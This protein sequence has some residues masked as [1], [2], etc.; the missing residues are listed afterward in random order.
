[1]CG[2]LMTRTHSPNEAFCLACGRSDFVWYPFQLEQAIHD[3]L[4]RMG[5][6]RPRIDG[7]KKLDGG[8]EWFLSEEETTIVDIVKNCIRWASDSFDPP[9]PPSRYLG[10][11]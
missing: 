6:H 9:F 3:V 4:K 1:M 7:E 5:L 8:T 11:S 10:L 2:V